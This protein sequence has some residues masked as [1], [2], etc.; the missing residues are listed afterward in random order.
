MFLLECCTSWS[1]STRYEYVRPPIFLDVFSH[2]LGEPLSRWASFKYQYGG[3]SQNNCDRSFVTWS[4]LAVH[5]FR[6]VLGVTQEHFTE[7]VN[8]RG[9]RQDTA[10]NPLWL[11]WDEHP[12]CRRPGWDL[13]GPDS[14]VLAVRSASATLISRCSSMSFFQFADVDPPLRTAPVCFVCTKQRLH[15]SFLLY[16][17][18]FVTIARHILKR[19]NDVMR[20]KGVDSYYHLVVDTLMLTWPSN[21]SLPKFSKQL[22]PSDSL[23]TSYKAMASFHVL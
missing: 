13:A 19:I 12:Y 6:K 7:Y 17:V 14:W 8:D 21:L 16:T 9:R 2:H 11:L 3:L 4:W 18:K 5:H 20:C 1:I 23:F 10:V 22:P 15:T